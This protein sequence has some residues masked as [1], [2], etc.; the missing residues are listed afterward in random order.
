MFYSIGTDNGE[1]EGRRDR[2]YDE[3]CKSNWG[4]RL[5]IAKV[6]QVR[7]EKLLREPQQQRLID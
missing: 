4:T 3:V 2:L 5:K 1:E 7:R 6:R